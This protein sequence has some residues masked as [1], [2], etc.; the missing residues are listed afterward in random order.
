MIKSLYRSD[1]SSVNEEWFVSKSM[2]AGIDYDFWWL[3]ENGNSMLR[4]SPD[5]GYIVVFD[6]EE[7]FIAYKLAFEL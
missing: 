6:K 3:G 5:R 2:Q 4:T 7:D 1:Y